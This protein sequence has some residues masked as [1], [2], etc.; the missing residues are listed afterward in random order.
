MSPIVPKKT[1]KF[2]LPGK[3]L[4]FILTIL[5]CILMVVS[6]TTDVISKP[7]NTFMGYVIVPYQ[8]GISGVGSYLKSRKDELINIRE[9]IN[10]NASLKEK[11]AEL[12]NENIKLMQDKYELNSL[13]ELYELDLTYDTY[14]KVGASVIYC[15][16]GNWFSTFIIDKGYK[17]GIEPDMNVIAGRG[18]V[19]RITLVGPNWSKVTSII[20]DNFNVS[21]TLIS[22]SENLIV[23]GN[24]E[25]IS[26]DGVIEFSQ[27]IDAEAKAAEGDKIV[28]S[29]ISDKYLPGLLIG[30]IDKINNDP[31]NLTKSGYLV[32]VVDF[33]HLDDVLIILDKKQEITLEEEQKGLTSETYDEFMNSS[34]EELSGTDE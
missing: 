19:G 10:E 12:E 28:T 7:L 31:N 15:D 25:T 18:L 27:L 13:R 22:T 33:E 30:Y 32:P 20:S 2:T 17:D 16:S 21:G 5:C 29:D 14:R 11:V 4:L 24:L 3:Y 9:L 26:S 23:S 1:E 6:V 8:R 34:E